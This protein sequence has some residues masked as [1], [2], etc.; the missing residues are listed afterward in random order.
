[1]VCAVIVAAG[2]SERMCGAD[3]LMAPLAGKPVLQRCMEAFEACGDVDAICLV[4][5]PGRL[6]SL[7]LLAAHWGI[8]KLGY[9]VEG[10]ATRTLSVYNGLKALPPECDIV[11]IQ[12]GAR[13]FTANDVIARSVESARARGSGVAAVRSR[14]T[15]KAADEDGLVRY[16]PDRRSLWLVQTPQTFRFDMILRAYMKALAEGYEAT[17]DAAIAE[18]AGEKVYLL[19]G[20]VDNIKITTPEDM[21]H[22]EALAR[23]RDGLGDRTA[24]IG[25]GYDAHRLVQGRALILGG[26]DIPHGTGLL[27]HSDADALAHAVI[28]ALLGAACLGDIGMNFPDSDGAYKDIS[29]LILLGKA[30]ELL[31]EKGIIVGNVDATIV[32]QRPKLAPHIPR[33][34]ENIAQALGI[35]KDRVSV[36]ATTTEGMGFEG[37]EEGISARAVALIYI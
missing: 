7:R 13:P 24:R 4:A 16:T 27:G 15:V 25:E 31:R 5:A 14:D 19:D 21:P 10:G 34:R 28:D 30:A 37:R 9:A 29:S 1:M 20:S 6:E 3:K 23:I 11:A 36:K 32:A 26:V 33:M 12:D 22:G 35:S 18:W 17:D 2:R 8:T